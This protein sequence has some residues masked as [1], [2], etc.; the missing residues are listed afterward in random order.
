MASCARRGVKKKKPNATLSIK[1]KDNFLSIFILILSAHKTERRS[2]SAFLPARIFFR[3][4]CS[5]GCVRYRR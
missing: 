1:D 2:L 5:G 4:C 3:A